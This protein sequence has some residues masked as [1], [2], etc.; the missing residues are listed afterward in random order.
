MNF[1]T[2]ALLNGPKDLCV[3]YNQT[4][5]SKNGIIFEYLDEK[6]SD[7]LFN[8][9]NVH[10]FMPI[11]MSMS[12]L[13][14]VKFNDSDKR[15]Q[16]VLFKK[17]NDHNFKRHTEIDSDSNYDEYFVLVDYDNITFINSIINENNHNNLLDYPRY[18]CSFDYKN[19]FYKLYN[20]QMMIFNYFHLYESNKF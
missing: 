10:H 5:S 1:N 18:C 3:I 2:F 8:T 13:W 19:K 14:G 7:Q 16:F 17:V 9:L 15:F 4:N 20:F 11:K 6:I 12:N